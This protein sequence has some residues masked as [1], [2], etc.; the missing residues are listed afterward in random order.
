MIGAGDDCILGQL[1]G[2]LFPFVDAYSLNICV[3]PSSVLG[4][5][6]A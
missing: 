4:M 2:Q 1:A 3:A 5:E 6:E